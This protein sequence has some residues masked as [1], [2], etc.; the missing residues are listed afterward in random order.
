MRDP[1][2]PGSKRLLRAAGPKV[3]NTKNTKDTKDTKRSALLLVG[4]VSLAAS[5][6]DA[7]GVRAFRAGA[8]GSLCI[9]SAVE[10]RLDG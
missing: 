1:A 9:C 10:L 3:F 4:F 2:V 7:C 8:A 6:F 5:L